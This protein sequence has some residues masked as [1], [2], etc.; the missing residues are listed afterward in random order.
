MD[1]EQ[2]LESAIN[3]HDA[4]HAGWRLWFFRV[5]RVLIALLSILLGATRFTAVIF[6]LSD[7]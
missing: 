7:Y 2:Q 4:R 1:G 3:C 5:L 6:C